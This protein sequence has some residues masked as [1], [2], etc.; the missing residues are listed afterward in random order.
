MIDRD[1]ISRIYARWRQLDDEFSPWREF[2]RDVAEY[3]WPVSGVFLEEEYNP[4]QTPKIHS[5]LLHDAGEYANKIYGA[6]FQGGLCSP[7]REWFRLTLKDRDRAEFHTVRDWL[8]QVEKILYQI[9]RDSNFY[10]AAHTGFEEQ[11]AFGTECL[12]MT[13]HPDRVVHFYP[14]SAGEYRIAANAERKIDTIYRQTWMTAV[15]MARAFGVDALSTRTK[16]LLDSAPFTWVKVLHVIEPRDNYDPTKMDA[17]N[18]P[19]RSVWI[20]DGV[21]DKVLR[22]SG[23]KRFPAAVTRVATRG[24]STYGYG[25]GHAVLGRTKLVQEMEKESL[26]GL[27]MMIHPPV[28]VPPQYEGVLNLAPAGANRVDM[29][30]NAGIRPIFEVNLPVEAIEGKIAQVEQKIA[31]AFYND[32][33]LMITNVERV[34]GTPPTATEIMERKEEKMLML[35]PSVERQA[36]EKLGPVIEFTFEAALEAGRIP[37]PPPE[38]QGQ[39]LE[40]EYISVLAQAQKLATA[41]GLRAYLAEVE[42]VANLNPD[43]MLKTDLYE[44][45]EQYGQLLGI[46]SKVMVPQN[47][48]EQELAA[49]QQQRAQQQQMEQAAQSAQIARSLGQTRVDDGSALA[50]LRDQVAV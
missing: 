46:P 13:T 4:N 17:L 25:P 37:P 18:M 5:G 14:L 1:E 15:A 2:Y 19:W 36:R 49:I 35:G 29:S 40:I 11:G 50:E 32:L 39:P 47:E 45:L 23:F 48:V 7:S 30:R 42:R 33:F 3:I 43:S 41:Q 44:Y 28:G 9:F 6:G 21:T 16:S 26:T 22:E 8:D 12:L 31:R 20:E 24:Q 10:P 27:K 38:L 34:T